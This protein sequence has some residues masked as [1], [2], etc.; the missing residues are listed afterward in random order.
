MQY[1]AILKLLTKYFTSTPNS[2]QSSGLNES[3]PPT[4]NNASFLDQTAVH[5]EKLW[6]V[7]WREK[8]EDCTVT[9]E[10]ELGSCD[11]EN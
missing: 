11:I 1:Q 9:C 2:N 5:N 8:E 4:C 3:D 7:D 6:F 10:V